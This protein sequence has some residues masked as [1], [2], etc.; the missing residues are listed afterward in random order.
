MGKTDDDR[1]YGAIQYANT[2]HVS[3]VVILV[4]VTIVII[5]LINYFLEKHMKQHELYNI[6]QQCKYKL[7]GK[8]Q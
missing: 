2:D 4:T 3:A 5:N 6:L 8:L 1:V 7:L